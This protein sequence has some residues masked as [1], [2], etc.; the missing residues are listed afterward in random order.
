LA[1]PSTINVVVQQQPTI[2]VV[3]SRMGIPGPRGPAG[4]GF[5]WAGE[6]TG[7]S[8]N[9]GHVAKHRGAIWISLTTTGPYDEPSESSPKW[10]PVFTAEELQGPSGPPGPVVV[11]NVQYKRWFGIGPPTI[12]VG[13]SPG[14][15]YVDVNN[16]D[17]FI[18]T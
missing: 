4:S 1:E 5:T 15:E 17:L 12:V 14:D 10:A 2:Q 8:H 3:V 7:Q 11:A 13:S 6:W 16:G 18:L 9:Q